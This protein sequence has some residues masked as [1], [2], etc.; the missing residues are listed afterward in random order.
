M[1]YA[2]IILYSLIC[3]FAFYLTNLKNVQISEVSNEKNKVLII[4][5]AK[6]IE[7]K[8]DTAKA[9]KNRKDLSQFNRQIAETSKDISFSLVIDGDKSIF[10]QERIMHSDN[11]NEIFSKLAGSIGGTKG[12]F[13][14]DK[15]DSICI[16]KKN[17][18]DVSFDVRIDLNKWSITK[19]TKLINDF[20]CFKA[21][22]NDVPSNIIYG[23]DNIVTAWFTTELP[24]FFGPASY[25]GLPG[26]ILEVSNGTITLKATKIQFQNEL[27]ID[28]EIPQTQ[29]TITEEEYQNKALEL[30]PRRFRKKIENH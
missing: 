27:N 21:T 29:E 25:F 7:R 14:I 30:A 17:I 24:G 28:I 18:R 20:V 1:N 26:T 22:K 2:K 5:Y 11:E 19:E 23:E 9:I 16:N 15:K 4:N 13:Y 3:L 12:I 10:R 8:L 6:S